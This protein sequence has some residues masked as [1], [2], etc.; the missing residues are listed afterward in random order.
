MNGKES[1]L[2]PFQVELLFLVTLV[3]YVYGGNEWQ[4]LSAVTDGFKFQIA[5]WGGGTSWHFV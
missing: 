1:S 3:G 5:M 4:L 2:T